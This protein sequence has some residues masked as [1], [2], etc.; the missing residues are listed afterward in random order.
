VAAANLKRDTE[1]TRFQR[2]ERKAESGQRSTPVFRPIKRHG[3]ETVQVCY[4]S[5]TL[6][7][8]GQDE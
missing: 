6:T 4:K 3:R 5:A 1:G 7:R 8:I 2:W